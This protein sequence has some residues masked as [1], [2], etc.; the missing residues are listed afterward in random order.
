MSGRLAPNEA[1][2]V[3]LVQAGTKPLATIEKRKNASAYALAT[4]LAAAGSLCA[5]FITSS[6]SPGGDH[7]LT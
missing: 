4:A 6:D 2:E 1:C 3:R 5:V 7:Y